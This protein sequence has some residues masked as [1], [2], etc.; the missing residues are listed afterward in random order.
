MDE[1]LDNFYKNTTQYIEKYQRELDFISQRL[2]DGNLIILLATNEDY[3]K[4]IKNIYNTKQK[5]NEIIET[6]KIKFE[7]CINIKFNGYLE[8]QNE[9]EENN[10]TFNQIIDRALSISY[11]LDNNE[12]IDKTFDKV[13][14]FI[15]DKFLSLLE[16]MNKSIKETFPLEENVL[17]SSLFDEAYTIEIDEFLKGEK[18]DILQF[19]NN[20]NNNFLN[21]INNYITTFKDENEKS[22]NQIFSG[23]MEQIT[24]INLD[25]LNTAFKDS[26][27]FTFNSITD[28][29][30]NNTNNAYEYLNDTQIASSYH[31]TEGFKNKYN[32]FYNSILRIETFVNQNL[33]NNLDIKYKNSINKIRI[34]LQSIKLNKLLEKYYNQLPSAETHLNS[35][36]DLFYIFEKYFSDSVYNTQFLPLINNFINSTNNNLNQIK[37]NFENIYDAISTKP[38]DSKSNDFDV[39]NVVRGSRY[40]CK[41]L[42]GFCRRHCYHPDIITYIGKNVA[43]TNNYLNLKEIDFEE[44]IKNYDN[45]YEIFYQPFAENVES[46]NAL[47]SQLDSFIESK[48]NEYISSET[49]YLKNIPE[50]IDSL[51]KEK[52]G[53]ILLQSSYNYFKNKITNILPNELNNIL[54]QWENAFDEIYGEINS[55]KEKFKSEIDEFFI[56]PSYFVEVYKQNIS[57]D[58]GLSVVNKLKNEFFYTNKYYYNLLISKIKNTY[59]Y[60]L[61]NIPINEKPFDD[62]LNFRIDE[63]K[64]CNENIIKKIQN[65]KNEIIDEDKQKIILK[66]NENNFFLSNDIIS[67]HIKNFESSM[68]EKLINL[69]SLIEEIT[70]ESPEELMVAKFYL[71]NSINGKQIKELYDSINKAT[72]IDLQNNVYQKLID[73]TWKIDKDELVQNIRNALIKLNENNLKSFNYENK[74]YIQIIENNLYEKFYT[75]EDLDNKIVAFYNN[76][77]INSNEI[78]KNQIYDIINLI[79]NKIKSH[80]INEASRLNNELTSY[81]NDFSKI[82]NRLNNYKT[83]IYEKVYSTITYVVNDIHQQI[84]E[85]FYKNYIKKGLNDYQHYLDNTDF[86]NTQFLNMSINLNEI[87]KKE[88]NLILSEY[89]NLTLNQIEFLFQKKIKNLDEQFNFSEIRLKI[90]EELDN[91]YNSTLFPVL[92]KVGLHNSG[93]QGISDYDLSNN[94]INDIDTYINEQINKMKQIIK[95]TEGNKDDLNDLIVVDFS[96]NKD[97]IYNLIKNRFSN[98]SILN[99]DK[100]KKEFNKYVSENAINNF[101]SLIN[102]FVPSFG[103]DFFKRILRFNEIQKIKMLYDDLK[104][105]LAQTNAFYI[106]LTTIDSNLHLPEDI[107]LKLL[108]LNNIDSIVTSNNNLIISKL[109]DKLNSFFEET[110]INIIKKYIKEITTAP[111]F[112]LK[113]NEN[114][115]N[116]IKGLISGNEYI[117]EKIYI[118]MMEQNIKTP[119][120]EEYTTTLNLATKDMKN[121]IDSGK[122]ELKIE[123]DNIFTLNSDSVLLDIQNKLEETAL[124]E[125]KCKNHLERFNI[126]EEVYDFLYNFGDKNIVPKYKY[127]KDLLNE[128][129]E[130]LIINNLEK[131]SNEF[132]NEY[133]LDNFK[134]EVNNV[135]QNLSTYFNTFESILNNYGHIESIYTQNLER[136]RANYNRRLRRLETDNINEQKFGDL[137]LDKTFYE[138]K[139]LFLL[140]KNSIESLNLFLIFED[141]INNYISEKNKQYSYT[142]YI[143][144]S[145]KEKDSNYDLITKRYEQLKSLSSEYYSSVSIIYNILKEEI[146]NNI[147]KINNLLISCEEVTFETIN[148]KYNEI[149]NEFNKIDELQD[150][151]KEEIPVPFSKFNQT[152]NY[153]TLETKIKNYLIHN[154]ISVD[155]LYSDESKTPK[156]V[157][158]V[159]NNIKPESFDINFYSSVGQKGKLGR[160][161]EFVFNNIT[162]YTNIIFDV[163][164]NNANI[165]TNFNFDEY[166][167]KIKHYEEKEI[168]YFKK[169]MGVSCPINITKIQYNITLEENLDIP[170]KNKTIIENYDF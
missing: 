2:N 146:F 150:D 162:S 141:K 41:K 170:L 1:L 57:Y 78:S 23:L 60:I 77:I 13:W 152:N 109:N 164:T 161:F 140:S 29:I 4:T 99:T 42:F 126:S 39:K 62:I 122:I 130:E 47:L 75:K 88:S 38:S 61:N 93:E 124:A 83:N 72:F 37:S 74:E 131:L 160:K 63:I 14:L 36:N 20:E 33:K 52:F 90:F 134:K 111:D 97:S 106:I 3:Q 54:N 7:E 120:I 123:L 16:Y 103:I 68:N 6:I 116:I 94:I 129:T 67:E 51:L 128:R 48:K 110:K 79:L 8:S 112:D 100:E 127:I 102:N 113:F 19:I 71:E 107:K 89:N 118:D 169:I 58:F 70:D 158:R 101:K 65:S 138:L 69:I 133:S 49:N 108:A 96:N 104:Y 98:F 117:Y 55:N 22:L 143:L 149:K 135:N 156:V 163:G 50:K 87:I 35:I 115:K 144:D 64:K 31:I 147:N 105:T 12:L 136:E 82:E 139:N 86:G 142:E 148:N 46:Y 24:A 132:I 114:L 95:I 76:G 145:Q 53:N 85:N 11:S 167:Y 27:N 153:F 84:F 166:N 151:T 43:G 165:I 21:S 121:F 10:K 15:R 30:I 34:S 32:I 28:I 73:E 18:S 154:K 157:G 45:K 119:F 81:S 56:V 92:E 80:I 155:L 66:V 125:N 5:V 159:E 44:Y 26:L 17:S 59:T 168:S 25:D 137:K 9:I 40:C 91:A